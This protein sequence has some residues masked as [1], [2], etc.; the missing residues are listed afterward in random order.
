MG[1]KLAIDFGTTNTVAAVWNEATSSA[2]IVGLPGLSLT[3]QPCIQP[4][5][6]ATQPPLVPSL[7][8]VQ[9]GETGE[10]VVGQAVRERGLDRQRNNRLF[11][12]FKRGIVAAPPPDPR[13][14]DGRLWS[15]RVAGQTF[16][17]CLIEAMPQ[18]T[19][20]IEQ[21]VLSAPVASFEGYLGWLNEVMSDIGPDKIRIVDESTAAALGYAVTEP[22]ALVL[23]LDFGGGTLDLSLVQLPESSEQTGGLLRRLLKGRVGQY[24]AR[25]IAKAGRVIG[26]S[27]IDR[28]LLAH[29]LRRAN[30]DPQT[31]DQDYAPLLT[32]CEQ[33]KIALSSEEATTLTFDAGGQTHTLTLTRAE[34]EA[35]LRDN[36]FYA[37][38]SYVV[39]KVMH[40]AQR[41]SVYEEDLNYVL[42]VGG[43]S[44]MPSVQQTLKGLF[45]N[46]A[47]RADKPFTAVAEG[48]LQLAA[49]FGL[50]DYLMHGYGL[51]HLDPVSG[52]HT[53]DEIIPMGSHYPIEKPI[54]LTLGAAHADQAEIEFVVGEID[55]EA[56][57][58][59][60]LEHDENGAPVFVA[61]ANRD[62]QAIVPLNAGGARL[63]A[64]LD[65]PG[66]PGEDRLKVQF[67]VDDRRRLRAT[68]IDLRT[69]QTLLRDAIVAD[70][71][72]SPSADARDDGPTGR[73]PRLSARGM[74]GRFHL[75]LRG[76]GTLL[77]A[78]PPESI[79]VEAA[80][81]ALH[82]RDFYVRYN[83][84]RLLG[85]RGDRA[86]RLIFQDVL[87]HGE[88]PAR[89]SAA[90]ELYA[91]SW[92]GAEPLIRRA[93]QDED[94]RVREGAVYALC[95]LRD[96]NAYELLVEVLDHGA[97]NLREAAAWG[98]RDCQDVAAVPVLVA[99]LKAGDPDVRVKG[100]EALGANQTAEAIPVVRRAMHDPDPDVMYAATLSWLELEGTDCLDDLSAEIE[101]SSGLMRRQILRGLFH[102]TNY[103]QLD[104]V[105]T[106]AS[107][108]LIESIGAAMGDELPETR[109]AATWPLAWLRHPRAPILL[110]EAYQ[111][112]PR[113]EV[114]AHI[115]RCAV[116][117][118]SDAAEALLQDAL[119]CADEEVRS[120]ARQIERE[121][122]GHPIPRYDPN[123]QPNP[124]VQALA[125]SLPAHLKTGHDG[126]Q[127][128]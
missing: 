14:I 56:V 126:H 29:V 117:L 106:P 37:A 115:V 77:N 61:K 121:Q 92:F 39:D 22:G 128:S 26:G 114:K 28:W 111:R 21:L 40:A 52:R 75:S 64:R 38:L 33:A 20:D 82:S 27:D 81:A 124:E 60:E 51:R 123:P 109:K 107:D 85:R 49:G 3:P 42:L 16:L 15:D 41:R 4:A 53:Y 35:L 127:P 80:A 70:L 66:V 103:L 68:L 74:T 105:H 79:S 1:D 120:V 113:G 8:Y 58:T 17:H 36:G 65:P 57:S 84:A 94:L 46:V 90:R 11:R 59:I 102:A 95:D 99:V 47:G 72:G 24:S 88:A 118:M 44:L 12:N 89:A 63:I 43:V 55:T 45:S 93:L 78:L 97:D 91:F 7:L 10:I 108:R 71:S 104:V 122:A 18:H 48:A 100:L 34:L 116:Y 96:L 69:H 50:E 76:L 25:V 112:E 67:T 30:V 62:G 125:A 119:T 86:A 98:L 13:E 31:L 87:A 2:E 110:S 73:E 19:G 54:E 6:Q 83:A 23:V 101:R 9:N 32:A 5:G